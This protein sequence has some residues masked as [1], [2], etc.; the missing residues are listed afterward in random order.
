[1]PCLAI[2]KW[3]LIMSAS[4]LEVVNNI[5]TTFPSVCIS[6]WPVA[7]R[8]MY[9]IQTGIQW[10]LPDHVA[11]IWKHCAKR[12]CPRSVHMFLIFYSLIYYHLCFD[13]RLC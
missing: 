3:C 6:I 2:F 10:L 13:C 11:Q 1:M 12:P 7:I 5:L 8:Y 4:F 9:P